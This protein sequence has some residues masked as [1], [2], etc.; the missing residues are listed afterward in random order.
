L[1]AFAK[2]AIILPVQANR[3]KQKR[4]K[5]NNKMTTYQA[6]VETFR[7]DKAA[8]YEMYKADPSC[9]G[10]ASFESFCKSM[11]AAVERKDRQTESDRHYE[12]TIG[13]FG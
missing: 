7:T 4:K 13:R 3:P 11:E 6:T 2:S 1:T 8:A 9:I 12:M 10:P 5:E